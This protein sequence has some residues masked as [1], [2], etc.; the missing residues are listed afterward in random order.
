MYYKEYKDTGM[1]FSAL[2][3]GCM[4]L[5]RIS[6]ESQE[7]DYEKA[8]EIIDYAYAHGINY[9]DTAYM[10]HNGDSE[11]FIGQALKKYPRESYYLTDKMPVWMAESRADVERIFEDQFARTGVDYFDFYLM[12]S[13]QRG[14]WEKYKEYGV[15]E[16]LSEQKKKGRIRYLGFSFHDDPELL[17]EIV[18]TYD[19]DFAQIQCNYVDWVNQDAKGQYEVLTSHHIPVIVMEPVRG[20]ALANPGKEALELLKAARPQESAA[21]WAIRFNISKPNVLVVLS[22]MSSIEQIIDN[23]K[24][25]ENFEP[26]TAEEEQ[27]LEQAADAYRRK[28]VIPCTGCRYCMDCPFGLDIPKNFAIFNEF[29][30]TENEK[31][32]VA[33]MNELEEQQRATNC[34]ACGKCATHCP[35]LIGIPDKMKMIAEKYK[36]Y[37]R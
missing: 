12:H 32:F 5:P 11:R 34:R 37:N 36:Q 24:T 10:Y 17:K 4:R 23:V 31:V 30:K 8:Q 33:A 2:G 1:K 26:L 16:F 27:L 22:G 14:N 9:Y 35:Q 29:T 13:V 3:M 18:E 20:G 25:V 19:F 6:A 21:S 28:D 7:V 15:Y